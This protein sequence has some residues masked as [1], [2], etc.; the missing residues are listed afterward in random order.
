[1]LLHHKLHGNVAVNIERIRY[2]I[3]GAAL[4]EKTHALTAAACAA[5]LDHHARIKVF[6]QLFNCLLLG[7]RVKADVEI[8]PVDF[9]DKRRRMLY[10]GKDNIHIVLVKEGSE[11]IKI[12]LAPLN[13][14][15]VNV[16]PDVLG[17]VYSGFAAVNLNPKRIN[18]TGVPNVLPS[19]LN[20]A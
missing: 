18:E 20:V 6:K 19:I 14:I 16:A 12:Y 1:M 4:A 2:I 13:V 17:A 9:P 7:Y 3:P 5:Y 11:V 10:A 8:L 15:I